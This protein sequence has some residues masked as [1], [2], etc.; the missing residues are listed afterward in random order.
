MVLITIV[1]TVTMDELKKILGVLTRVFQSKKPFSFIVNCN[2]SQI[3]AEAASLTKYLVSWM[4]DSQED[5]INYLQCTSIIIKSEVLSTLINGIF[6]IHGPI[7]P[8]YITTDAK[9]GERFVVDIMKKFLKKTT[10]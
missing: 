6:K 4:K 7:K 5:I 8:N 1:G 10:T 3:P 9:L 2:F